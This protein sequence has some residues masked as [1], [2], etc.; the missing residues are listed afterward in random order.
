VCLSYLPVGLR[1]A[2]AQ[3]GKGYRLSATHIS[4]NSVEH[5]RHWTLPTHA[6]D[7]TTEG[8]VR[9]HF[10][11]GRYNVLD[12][13]GRSTR[14]INDFRRKPDQTAVLN[15]DSAAVVD[16]KGNAITQKVKGKV[17][18]LY[19][20]FLRPGISRVGSNPQNAA[21]IL[22]GD[23][24]TYWEPDPADPLDNWWIEVDLGKVVPVDE[25]V[26]R[27]VG[28]E[29]GDPFWKFRVLAAPDQE[30]IDQLSTEVDFS[31]VGGTRA[32]N[33]TQREFRFPLQQTQADPSWTGR[34]AQTIR[35]VVTETRRGRGE[36]VSAAQWQ[37]LAPVDRGDIVYFIKDQQGFEEPLDQARLVEPV[38]TFYASLAPERQGRLE[39]YRRERPRLADVQVW[40]YG[41]NLSPG[42]SAG[43]GS[44]FLSGGNFAPGPGFDGD[45]TTHFLH[46]VW[47]PLI[48]RGVLTVDM[49]ATFFLDAIR[50][51]TGGRRTFLDGYIMR[52]SD[53]SR[54][55]SGRLKWRRISS[56]ARE[57]NSIDQFRNLL[58]Q[59]DGQKLRY[60]EMT[61]VSVDPARRGGYNTG[62]DIAEYQLFSGGYPAEVVLTSDLIELPAARN[63]GGITWQ[64]ET[65]PGTRLEIR[66]RTGDL[67]GKVIR[68]YDK[69]GSEITFD[70]WDNLLGSFKG[71]ADTLF[72]PTSG[73]SPWSRTYQ[74][75]GDRVSSPGLRKYLQ[76]Q[77]KMDTD[78]RQAATSI[79][80]IDIELFSPVAE[81]ILAELQPDAVQAAGRTDTFEVFIQPNFIENPRASRSIG[82]DE[83]L[84]RMPASQSMELLELGV[85]ARGGRPEQVFRPSSAPDVLVSGDGEQLMVLR[86]RADSIWVRFLTPLNIL[87][88][89]PRVYSRVTFEGDQVPVT[90]DGL[91]LAGSAYG[92]LPKEEQGDVRY[93]RRAATA[94]GEVVLTEVDV[95][96]YNDLPEESKG[97]IRYFRILRGDGGQFPFDAEGD[98]LGAADYTRLSTD[99]KGSVIGPGP[100]VRLRFSAPVFLNGTTL[101][102]AVRN[103]AGGTA[104]GAAWQSIEAGD[105]TGQVASNAL[106]I[107]V[108]LTGGSIDDFSIAPNPFTPN[109]DGIND[110][111]VIGFSVF[112]I[113]S[114]R[115]VRV[116]IYALDGRLV[117]KSVQP[118]ESGHASVRWTGMDEGGARVPPG[119]YVARVDL[120][121]DDESRSASRPRV[122]SVVY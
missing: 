84:L 72:V 44:L 10:S 115:E 37:A 111:A 59:Y 57:D 122:V 54:D 89:A 60:L 45:F 65:P 121:A 76:I 88:D 51:S 102:M 19:A 12:D 33:R 116:C 81:H 87:P 23:P 98:S 43:G 25:I 16:V 85:A 114:P 36:L 7:V 58:D 3:V 15:V 52:G 67:L 93:F 95:A 86:D 18:P 68:Y 80:A 22:D 20:Y 56:P 29:L 34:L 50:V 1:Q 79:R 99:T 77:V 120:D 47:S 64:A 109:G 28:E 100:L 40:G 41:D 118:I 48:E 27:F 106:S 8:G 9:P 103:T 62:A 26:L 69:S 24:S 21:R 112:R 66:T 38:K 110:G 31:T 107:S 55:A 6:V 73:W 35:I 101:E 17:V 97:P 113:T 91:P 14:P 94:R 61:V 78:D 75:P 119:L 82:F 108:P 92:L 74:Q 70:A 13:L 46:L 2:V 90:Q 83:L 11:R 39:H 105:A 30:P 71:P 104:A 32:P 42:I 96:A 63:F 49:G 53:G 5:W 4:V 117:W